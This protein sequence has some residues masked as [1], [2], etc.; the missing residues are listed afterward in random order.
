MH[1]LPLPP[2]SFRRHSIGSSS[3][4]YGDPARENKRLRSRYRG[5]RR[6]AGDWNRLHK[7]EHDHRV[8]PSFSFSLAQ[9]SNTKHSWH[10][11][12]VRFC[13]SVDYVRGYRHISL[14]FKAERHGECCSCINHDLRD[15]W[16]WAVV[17]GIGNER[18]F[19]SK[20]KVTG[21]PGRMERTEKVSGECVVLL[22]LRNRM[23]SARSEI[24]LSSALTPKAPPL[25]AFQPTIHQPQAPVTACVCNLKVVQPPINTEEHRPT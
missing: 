16:V 17:Y 13:G 4:G 23:V 5:W 10:F 15:N 20:E 6:R 18:L 11:S 7:C 9:A 8:G 2:L 19:I 1:G 3:A 21:A 24:F 25:S 22:S 12:V 14:Y